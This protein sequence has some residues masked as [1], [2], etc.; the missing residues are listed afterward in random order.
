MSMNMPGL[1][2]LSLKKPK[3]GGSNDASALTAVDLAVPL[4][5]LISTPPISGLRAFRTS[6]VFMVSWP[7][8]AVK[9]K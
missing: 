1:E 3:I 4:G 8:M 2:N 6:A 7:T 5:P 9:G